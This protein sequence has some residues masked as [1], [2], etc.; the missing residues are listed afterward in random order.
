MKKGKNSEYNS[1]PR[2]KDNGLK[3]TLKSAL[4]RPIKR[5]QSGARKN[6]KSTN[7]KSKESL[8]NQ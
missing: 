7:E 1:R 2:D 5:I 4:L 8:E 6:A 3:P